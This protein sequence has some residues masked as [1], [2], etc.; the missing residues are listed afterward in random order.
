[1][2]MMMYLIQC[3]YCAWV[4]TFYANKGRLCSR[5]NHFSFSVWFYQGLLSRVE[6]ISDRL[7]F[8]VFSSILSVKQGEICQTLYSFIHL[9]PYREFRNFFSFFFKNIKFE[10]SMST[11]IY[12]F[13]GGLINTVWCDQIGTVWKLT[14]FISLQL[15]NQTIKQI[16]RSYSLSKSVIF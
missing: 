12:F 3:T 14:L 6:V 7:S 13:K 1:M 2:M 5:P 11:V 15:I 4:Y 16:I 8:R 10:I 9:C